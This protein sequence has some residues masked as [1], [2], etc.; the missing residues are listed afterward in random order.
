[1]DGSPA[2]FGS[3]F[4]DEFA[5]TVE[6]IRGM[7]EH[8]QIVA[9]SKKA[10][11]ISARKPERP[12]SQSA[13]NLKSADSETETE[14]ASDWKNEPRSIRGEAAGQALV[15]GLTRG[16]RRDANPNPHSQS[17]EQFGTVRQWLI[18][19]VRKICRDSDIVEDV[20][21]SAIAEYWSKYV[22]GSGDGW[23]RDDS[24]ALWVLWRIAHNKALDGKGN[25]G[26]SQS[27]DDPANLI[28]PSENREGWRHAKEE[29]G[30]P[31]WEKFEY[32]LIA[33]GR[34]LAELEREARRHCCEDGE[35]PEC[36]RRMEA[37]WLLFFRKQLRLLD[38]NIA[39]SLD[40][41]VVTLRAFKRETFR[42][43]F[44]DFRSK[45][46]NFETK[47]KTQAEG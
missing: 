22:S 27:L 10:S 4:R 36:R 21:D 33:V 26:R 6:R 17:Q 24:Q 42:P 13:R 25:N 35:G 11:A 5:Q 23:L 38:E 47:F 18:K 14:P 2:G 29:G 15:N 28:D 19:R 45:V 7:I 39:E 30:G 46:K 43:L 32:L 16:D 3:F 41:S 34:Q 12:R 40:W 9:R 37:F 1:M 8:T 20:A 31:N 44:K